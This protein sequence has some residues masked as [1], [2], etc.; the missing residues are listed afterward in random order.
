MGIPRGRK[1]RD[2]RQKSMARE[3][4]AKREGGLKRA[5]KRPVLDIQ[6]WRS[7]RAKY[8]SMSH[9]QLGAHR[10]ATMNNPNTPSQVRQFIARMDI[11]GYRNYLLS[12]VNARIR[13]L[14]GK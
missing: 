13:Q 2:Y 12:Y 8:E 3:R 4:D 7:K 5:P 11:E 14:G 10:A 9:T 6:H 1:Y